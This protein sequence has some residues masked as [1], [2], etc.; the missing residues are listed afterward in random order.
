MKTSGI[1]I[2]AAGNS[3]RLGHAKQLLTFRNK[4]LLRHVV[5]EASAVRNAQTIVVLGAGKEDLEQELRG[6]PVVR[7]YNEDWS[8]GMAGSI[9]VGINKLLDMLP[10][11][12]C[13]IIAVCDQPYISTAIFDGLLEAFKTSPCKIIASS[14]ADTAGTPA[15]FSRDHFADLLQLKGQEG[16]KKLLGRYSEELH[17]VRFD[18][19]AVDIDT[20]EDYH[21]LLGES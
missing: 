7:C 1:I 19:G 17:L 16:A 20:E 5:D 10:E 13:C 8:S 3:S 11:V 15:L 9:H 6:T 4:T 18:Q 12:S 2:L 21:K 14:Y